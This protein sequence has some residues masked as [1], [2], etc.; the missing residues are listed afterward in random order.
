[1]T[2]QELIDRL[3][4]MKQPNA[5]VEFPVTIETEVWVDSAPEPQTQTVHDI[6]TQVRVTSQ[7]P[8]IVKIHLS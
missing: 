4:E 2:V 5:E 3:N 1:M 6:L 8:M 7:H